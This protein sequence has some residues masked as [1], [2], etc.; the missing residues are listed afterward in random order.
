MLPLAA[1]IYRNLFFSFLRK[2]FSIT[3]LVFSYQKKATTK[4]EK[5]KDFGAARLATILATRWTGNKLLLRVA[6]FPSQDEN[7]L[8]REI[9][10]FTRLTELH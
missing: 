2:T 6:L 4:N 5:K 7:N 3:I 9:D 8:E 1:G 10:F